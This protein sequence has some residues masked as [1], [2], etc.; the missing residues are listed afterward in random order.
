MIYTRLDSAVQ[1]DF[2]S[3]GKSGSKS[4]V[5]TPCDCRNVVGFVV[6]TIDG[7]EQVANFAFERRRAIHGRFANETFDFYCVGDLLVVFAKFSDKDF[8]NE[9]AMIFDYLI[10]TAKLSYSAY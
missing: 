10:I 3:D 2:V 8:E 7:D 5:S 9:F 6:G 1:A 4:C